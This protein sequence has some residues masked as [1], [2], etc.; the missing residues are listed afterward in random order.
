MD[1]TILGC[2]GVAV[3]FGGVQALADIHFEA[4]RGDI[5]AIIGPNGAGK[6]TLLNVISGMVTPSHGT[7]RFE[8][9]DITVLSTA[10]IVKSGIVLVPEGRRVFPNLTVLENLK[11]GAYLRKD[12]EGV[13]NDLE[14][15]HTLFPRLKERSWQLAGTLSGG[16]QQMLAVGRALREHPQ[17]NR[18]WQDGAIVPL[19]DSDVGMVVQVDDGLMT[20]VLR[21]VDRL[22]LTEVARQRTALAASVR[23]GKTSADQFHGGATSLTNLGR[24]RVDRFAPIISPPQSSMLAVGRVCERPAAFQ[25]QICLRQR[26]CLTL[27]VDHRVMDGVPAAEFLDRIVELLETPALLV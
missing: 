16:E 25:R 18:I 10:D 12:E 6:T 2:S 20:P 4:L 19:P 15:V 21:G 24:H 5:T 1:R 11:I 3:R 17:A 22:C 13:R 9:R 8:G 14:R 27:A 23:S 26:M 7:L